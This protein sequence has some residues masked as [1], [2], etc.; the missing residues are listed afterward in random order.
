MRRRFEPEHLRLV[1]RA[2]C[3]AEQLVW[4]F[5]ALSQREG[6]SIHYEVRTLEN[7]HPEEVT[8]RALAHLVC[9]EFVR[10]VG[11]HVLQRHEL[12]RICLQDHRLLEAARVLPP[13]S[14]LSALLLYVLTHELVHIIRFVSRLQRIDLPMSERAAEEAIVERTTWK[15][16]GGVRSLEPLRETLSLWGNANSVPPA[17]FERE[18]ISLNPDAGI[19]ASA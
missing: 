19:S 13:P 6:E 10:R 8:D 15:I 17:G 12:Y 14:D 9:Y 16:L 2:R 1:E 3:R 5:Y 18:R 7:L 11:S 4:Q